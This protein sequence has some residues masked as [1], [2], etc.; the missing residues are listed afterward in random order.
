MKELGF[1]LIP[2]TGDYTESYKKDMDIE[3]KAI[4]EL[5]F[6]SPGFMIKSVE[7]NSEMELLENI[8]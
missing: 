6:N 5:I 4:Q 7:R 2:E 8:N 1:N 3:N